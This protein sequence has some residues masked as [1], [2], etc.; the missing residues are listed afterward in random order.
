LNTCTHLCSLFNDG[1]N[2]ASLYTAVNE[3]D[4]YGMLLCGHAKKHGFELYNNGHN[5]PDNNNSR[6][7]STGHCAVLVANGER[8]FLTHLG[9]METFEAKDI[10][11]DHI[12]TSTSTMM[13]VH[14]AGYYNIPGFWNGQLKTTLQ[15]IRNAATEGDRTTPIKSLVTSL[16]CQYDATEAWDGQLMDLL[17]LVDYLF[18]NEVEVDKIAKATKARLKGVQQAE[19]NTAAAAAADQTAESYWMEMAKF[20]YHQSPNT[21]V[22]V[23]LGPKG[24]LALYD[25]QIMARQGAP[26]TVEHP[27]DPTGAGDAFI[28][29]FLYGLLELEDHPNSSTTSDGGL[30]RKD[31]VPLALQYGCVV[32]TS[33]ISKMGASNPAPRTEIEG[34]MKKYSS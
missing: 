29:G 33:C 26:I 4:P 11:T 18:C 17:P 19:E 13:Y 16:L 27:L 20:F 6:S 34:L 21:C 28:S 15:T 1:S 32:G 31:R 23:T 8:S 9:V 22:I 2:T 30:P 14:V 25:G 12:L 7:N 3:T 24:A 10:D 5:T